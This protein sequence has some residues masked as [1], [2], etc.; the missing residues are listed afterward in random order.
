M[1]TKR[2]IL[3]DELRGLTLLSM[4]IYHFMWDLVYL[5]NIPMPWYHSYGAHLWQQSICRTFILLSGFCWSLGK[6]PI[7]RGLTVFVCGAIITG[8]TGFLLPEDIVLFG[9]LTLLGSA[10]LLMVPLDFVFRKIESPVLLGFMLL[11]FVFL[12]GL[13]YSVPNGH[14]AGYQLPSSIYKNLFTAY[15]GFPRREF[16]STDYFP[17]LPWFF[18]Y[19]VGYFLQ[20]LFTHFSLLQKELFITSHVRPLAFIG[21][22]SLWIYMLHQPVLYAITL[23]IIK[24]RTL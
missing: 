24:I 11:L 17:I 19:A 6:H 22:K 23:C 4:I 13:F 1:N 5:A 9:V 20:K 8:V 12:F 15:L 7:K 3:L 14:L 10:M 2:L 21:Q 16:F 18:L